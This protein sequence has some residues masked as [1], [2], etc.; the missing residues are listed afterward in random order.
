VDS[1]EFIRDIMAVTIPS[2]C[3]IVASKWITNSWQSKKDEIETRR[4]IL[5]QLDLSYHKYYSLI[6][7]FIN[8]LYRGYEDYTPK[9][10]ING[11][12]LLHG[13]FFPTNVSDMPFNK[14]K[15]E[16]T[17]FQKEHDDLSHFMNSFGSSIALYFPSLIVK[18]NKV[19]ETLEVAFHGAIQ[20][21]Y[22]RDKMSFELCFDTVKGNLNK[23][24]EL[25]QELA[26]LI[27][28]SEKK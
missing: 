6:A 12:M 10:D 26:F 20:M 1:I 27:I 15:E 9:Y 19:D 14:F 23:A 7:N 11:K 22:C 17:T 21:Y 13:R 4:K 18:M 24:R 5:E 28:K 2:V 8:S 3:G 16:F 25:Q